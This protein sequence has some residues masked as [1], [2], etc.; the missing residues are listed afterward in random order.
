VSEPVVLEIDHETHYHYAAPVAQALHLAWLEP[1]HDD[2]Q[3]LI[4]HLLQI[5][6]AP[7]ERI[8]QTDAFG[9][10]RV[11]FGL[12]RP[13]QD[14]KVR[15]LSRVRLVPRPAVRLSASP[16]WEALRDRL[17]YAAGARFDPAVEFVQPS[18][19][20]PRLPGLRDYAAASFPRARPVAEGAVDLM[21]RIHADFVY[22]S[23]ST[24]VDTPLA[25]A[26]AQRRGVC[27]DFAHVMIGALRMLGLPARYVSGYLLT[28][29]AEG[30]PALVGADASHAWVQAGCG[31]ADD[32][33][34]LDPTNA[35]I[36]DTGHVRLAVGRDYGDVTPLRGV[37]RGGGRH[38][39]DVR[40][41]TA[42]VGPAR[43]LLQ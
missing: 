36:P 43:M 1:L 39:L 22:E 6:P 8:E 35:V 34:D 41:R 42:R 37:I 2:R 12:T 5:D 30:E 27:Q 40:V 11:F 19:Y 26:F 21:H 31:G 33:L 7:P 3:E 20:V 15:S 14:L 32:W 29:P 38:A 23:A 4:S 25:Q 18:P 9:N 24:T 28:T 10:R 17:R 16:P 13:H